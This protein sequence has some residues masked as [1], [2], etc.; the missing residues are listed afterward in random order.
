M[1][2]VPVKTRVRTLLYFM[3]PRA[4]VVLRSLMSDEDAYKSYAELTRSLISYFVHEINE[5][6]E[7]ARFHKQKQHPGKEAEFLQCPE[8]HAALSSSGLRGE[9]FNRKR[10][11]AAEGQPESALVGARSAHATA[12]STR[13]RRR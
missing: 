5:V 7:S 13:R 8:K 10:E 2:A 9:R 3:G 6:Y 4:R 11:G 1:H 12:S